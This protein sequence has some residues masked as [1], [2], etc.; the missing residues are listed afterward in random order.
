[1]MNRLGSKIKWKLLIPITLALLA[2][3]FMVPVDT[4]AISTYSQPASIYEDTEGSYQAVSSN[5]VNTFCYG[6]KSIGSFSLSGTTTKITTVN[7]FTAY[8]VTDT[9]TIG[10]AYDGSYKTKDKENWNLISAS[11]K[12]MNGISLSK[13][14]EDGVFVIQKSADSVNWENAAEPICNFFSGKKITRDA[15]YT[16]SNE[17]LKA[18]TYFR[19]IIAYEM[20]RKTGEI[21][22]SVVPPR[23]PE[24][25]YEYRYCS[26]IYEFYACYGNNQ[27]SL[28]NLSTGEGVD[29]GASV[30][31]GFVI[32]KNGS[33]NDVVVEKNSGISVPAET[34]STISEAGT[35]KIIETT[36]LGQNYSYTI[37]V[38]NGIKAT[39]LAPAVYENV[40][41]DGYTEN[42][43]VTGKTSFGIT[44]HT[45]LMIGQ[46]STTPITRSSH[47]GFSAYGITG[48]STSLY[49]KLKDHDLLSADGWTIVADT[50]GKKSSQTIGEVQP[51]QINTGA[52]IIQTSTDGST[53]KS[54]ELSRYA[55]G[56]Y[57]TD[58]EKYYGDRGDVL[59]YTPD[60]SAVLNGLYIRVLYAYEIKRD[61]EDYRC[62][63]KY[64]FYL[65]SNELDAVAFH[66]LSANGVLEN[67]LQEYDEA[68]AAVYRQAETMLTGAYTTTGFTIDT[69]LNPTVTYTVIKN[70]INVGV[71]NNREYTAEGKYVIT[72]NSAVNSKRTVEFYVDRMNDEEALKFYFGE[73]FLKGKRIYSEEGYPVY[74]GGVT[75]YQLSAVDQYH[76]PLCGEIQN[77]SSGETIT[78]PAT[79][80]EK[81]GVLNAP[82]EYIATLSTNEN[83]SSDAASGDCRTFTFR[84][85]VIAE[86]TAP[87]PT[88]NRENLT[89]Y[90]KT[91]ISDAY[92]KYFGLTYSSAA[93]GNITLAFSTREAAIEY[94]YN[95]EKG[96]VE[97]QPDGTYRY[98]GKL[99]GVQK[100]EYNSTWD[101]T[102]AMYFFA[103]QA[104]QELYFDL[105][106]QFTYRTL[107]GSLIE[108][109]KNLR[110]LELSQ[111]VT[112]FADGQKDA[113]TAANGLPVI[114]CK[115]YA[116]LS[117]GIT[118]TVT[119]G[120]SD[121]EFVKDKYGCDSAS[122]SIIDCTGREYSIAYNQGVGAQLR[123]AG[124]P[125][126]TVTVK[127]ST[128]YGD[129][130]TYQAVFL[131]DNDCPAELSLA[132]Y[133]DGEEKP[134]SYT[135][136]DDGITINVDAFRIAN[137][138]DAIDPY[139]MVRVTDT[140]NHTYYYV[141][142]QKATG[143]WSAPGKYD[144]SVVNRLGFSYTIHVVV[145][146]S[147]YTALVFTGPGTENTQSIITFFGAKNIRLPE[148]N[149]RGYTLSGFEDEDGTLYTT[150]IASIV[151]KGN[152]T[153]K[154]IWEPKQYT[155]SFKDT[156]G[157]DLCRPMTVNYGEVY[158]LPTPQMDDGYVFTGWLN[159]GRL[160]DASHIT[161]EEEADITLIASIKE[162]E[163]RSEDDLSAPTAEQP[164]QK[165]FPAVWILIPAL[166][167]IPVLVFKRREK[168]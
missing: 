5:S 122:V 161:I 30:V 85:H 97:K 35:Y 67:K 87:G 45:A 125:T 21:P 145:S 11:G 109:T 124:C 148:I 29:S 23:L 59:V 152:C 131:A 18:G 36:P 126:G 146:D 50:W 37:T 25:I 167:L 53:W 100:E 58:Y 16:V 123:A 43:L 6:K 8:G 63:E 144:V 116:Y 94:A 62:I 113:L 26:E 153:L 24:D 143:A 89:A 47:N 137:I 95:Y 108:N 104:V 40:K 64:E 112:I 27:I 164:E 98:N 69:S 135:Q 86:G 121:F 7:G 157:H 151:F 155:L 48:N 132:F 19:I 20:G 38:T 159:S 107:R 28:R 73:S 65:C 140:E 119:S 105:T 81:V 127:E 75:S 141:A 72:L 14:V 88:V 101:L 106:D 83:F 168:R 74:E 154:A 82:G 31:T 1:M 165:S 117:P 80:S 158:D 120:Y 156:S 13:K 60:G 10:Y 111:S 77:I 68:T 76:L 147:G 96:L 114:S 66:N 103:E 3:L 56:L 160:L 34:L 99:I 129:E 130:T 17:E 2:V 166:A 115:P 118:G 39:N 55:D 128:I 41:K 70:G 110:T 150:E 61:K 42:H 22:G 44:S 133:Q 49:L 138:V 57:T 32:D 163:T 54:E 84:F 142:D 4:K 33:G 93:A 91:N 149:R 102:D 139:S 52:I 136:T 46:N 51:G 78:I 92:P 71:P 15:L 9:L 162:T 134:A 79:R 12:M 90:A